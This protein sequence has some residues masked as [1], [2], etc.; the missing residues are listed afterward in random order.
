MN[1]NAERI[2]SV[3]RSNLNACGAVIFNGTHV[4]IRPAGH[5]PND[6][7]PNPLPAELKQRPGDQP[8]PVKNENPPIQDLVIADIQRRKELGIQRYGTPLQA[9]NG[10]DALLDAYEESIDKTIYLK[11]ELIERTAGSDYD[12]MRHMFAYAGVP[13]EETTDISDIAVRYIIIKWPGN[14]ETAMTFRFTNYKLTHGF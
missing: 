2:S 6:E 9:F 5:E 13:F 8:L 4:C 11:Q 14:G 7:C 3:V 1:D 10:R 12:H